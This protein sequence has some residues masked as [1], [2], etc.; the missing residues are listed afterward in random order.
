MV[1]IIREFT[2]TGQFRPKVITETIRP[3][4]VKEGLDLVGLSLH[5]KQGEVLKVLM[6]VKELNRLHAF[7]NQA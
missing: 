1:K 6:D 4:M 5:T 3:T 7:A 2:S